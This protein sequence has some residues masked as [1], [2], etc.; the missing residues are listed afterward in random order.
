MYFVRGAENS[1]RGKKYFLLGRGNISSPSDFVMGETLFHDTG[2]IIGH[3]RQGIQILVRFHAWEGEGLP[4][5]PG[6]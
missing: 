2:A 6:P 1:T 4:P 5:V 3:K